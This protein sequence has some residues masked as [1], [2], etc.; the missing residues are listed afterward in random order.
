[1]ARPKQIHQTSSCFLMFNF[2][3]IEIDWRKFCTVSQ[4]EKEKKLHSRKHLKKKEKKTFFENFLVDFDI[5]MC[6]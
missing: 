4:Q 2:H 1:M 5:E 3:H 6:Q